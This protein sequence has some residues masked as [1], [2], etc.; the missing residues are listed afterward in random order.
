MNTCI[1]INAIYSGQVTNISLKS[2]HGHALSTLYLK[3]I[4]VST[5]FTIVN[6]D[7]L[8]TLTLKHERIEV[9]LTQ[10]QKHT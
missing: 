4:S 3:D 2:F 7:L 10:E 6:T 8:L 5:L 9:V 1:I